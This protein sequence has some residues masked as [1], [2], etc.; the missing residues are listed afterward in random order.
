MPTQSAFA[1]V[2]A[3]TEEAKRAGIALSDDALCTQAAFVRSL[4][5]EVEH[6]HPSDHWIAPL[7]EQLAEELARLEQL[8][9]DRS[10]EESTGV[11]RAA[12]AMVRPIDVLVVDDDPAALRAATVALRDWGYRSRTVAS[13]EEALQAYAERPAD[14]V[15]SDWHMPGKNG[16]ELCAALKREPRPPYVILVTAF[17]VDE[18][19]LEGARGKADDFLTKPID[20]AELEGRLSAASRLVRALRSATD[21]TQKL[22]SHPRPRLPS[23][24]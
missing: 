10:R 21:L 5:D 13:A 19:L 16:L 2:N 3:L 12:V 7:H 24:T 4:V 8:V 17:A 15:V 22:R 20:L 11:D 6:R 9:V 23:R 14:I 18:Q 1:L